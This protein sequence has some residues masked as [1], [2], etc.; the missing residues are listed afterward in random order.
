MT[1]WTAVEATLTG[2]AARLARFPAEIRS[3]ADPALVRRRD[4]FRIAVPV[5]LRGSAGIWSPS[6]IASAQVAVEELNARSGINGRQVEIVMVDA[7]LEAK[8]PVE[9]LVGE[10]L[11]AN[12]VDAIVGMHISTVRQRLRR[13]LGQRV[14]YIYTPLYEGGETTPGVFSIGE[15]PADYLGPAIDYLHNHYRIRRWALIGNDYVWPRVSHIYAKDKIRDLGGELV[16][17]HY[18][19]FGSRDIPNVLKDLERSGAEAV[20]VSLA[21]QDAVTFNRKFG[22]MELHDKMIRLACGLEENGLLASGIEGLKRLYAPLSYFGSIQNEA[23]AAFREKY[24]SLHGDTAPELNAMGQSMYE[25]MHFLAALMADHEEDWRRLDASRM[26][27]L[28]HS[29]ARLPMRK[30]AEETPTSVYLA[31]ANDLAYEVIKSL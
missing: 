29:N 5:A 14:P 21:G 23:N 22:K 31:R 27:T 6:C 30:N 9:E 12:L 8:Q 26:R 13:V 19:P 4:V 2:T 15:T 17:E 10:L 24:Y 7:A 16:F 1:L 20:S 11:D 18:L 3:S 25:G 28:P